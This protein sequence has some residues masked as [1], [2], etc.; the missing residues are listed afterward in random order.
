MDILSWESGFLE[1]GWKVTSLGLTTLVM[2]TLCGVFCVFASSNNDNRPGFDRATVRL[3]VTTGT[4]AFAFAALTIAVGGKQ[5][6]GMPKLMTYNVGVFL[7]LAPVVMNGLLHNSA[8]K[9][10]IAARQAKKPP[11]VIR[12][13][14]GAEFVIPDSNARSAQDNRATAA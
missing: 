13:A 6:F 3:A 12:A 7:L 1:A 4:W 11:I 8:E 5:L 9:K 14:N 10:T 2:I